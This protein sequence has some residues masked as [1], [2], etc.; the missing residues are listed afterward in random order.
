M[1][2]TDALTARSCWIVTDGKIGM[3]AQCLGLAEALGL[4]PVIKRVQ[5][6]KPWRWLPPNA[7]RSPLAH[8]GP[9][10]DDL[11]PPWPDILIASG[12]QTV[13][14]VAT[15]RRVSQGRTF[16][17]QIQNPVVGLSR[18][19][20]VVAPDHDRISGPNVITTTGSMT[21]ITARRLAEA[22]ELAAQR[23]AH[24]P[25]PLVAVC[26]GG[27][28]RAYRMTDA[29]VQRLA[30]G[31]TQAVRRHGAG[32]MVTLSRRTG[33]RN[34]RLLRRALGGLPAEIWDGR[35]DNPYF[36]ML[37]LADYVVVTCDSVNMV[38]E[39]ASTGKPVKVVMLEGG[40][41]KFSRFHES[42]K[43]G[44]I[45]RD[46]DGVLEDWSYTPL[47]E[48]RRVAAEIAARLKATGACAA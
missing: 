39:A 44:G 19:D 46:F 12:R 25:R 20:V 23:F 33:A 48:S 31:L 42:M 10:G 47:D 28:N 14:P 6:R 1:S 45:T 43:Q 2:N 7:I 37:G 18:F 9:K 5:I 8:L 26:V 16:T 11:R 34:A 22:A 40:S 21:R 41:P 27:D 30:S 3:E 15:V 4:D 36:G 17:V 29:V 35:G 38:C 13:A 32:L 24:L